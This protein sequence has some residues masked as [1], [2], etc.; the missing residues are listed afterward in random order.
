MFVW[1]F[2]VKIDG[3]YWLGHI[4]EQLGVSISGDGCTE[5]TIPLGR[6]LGVL[7]GEG[8]LSQSPPRS[9]TNASPSYQ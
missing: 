9:R 4:D 6:H 7:E 1:L 2:L 8:T 3:D 5:N